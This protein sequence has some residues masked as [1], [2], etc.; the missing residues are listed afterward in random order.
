MINKNAT[1]TQR[2]KT[3]GHSCES[4]NPVSLFS[5]IPV[6]TGMTFFLCAFVPLW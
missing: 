5:W 3:T 4:R 1:E 6:D 2:N